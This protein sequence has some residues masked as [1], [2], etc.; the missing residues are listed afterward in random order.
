MSAKLLIE[1]LLKINF[2]QQFRASNMKNLGKKNQHDLTNN[3]DVND[4]ILSGSLYDEYR[5][6]DIN[7]RVRRILEDE[8]CRSMIAFLASR[9]LGCSEG[10][11]VLTAG[12]NNYYDAEGLDS[13][14]TIIFLRMLNL[15]RDVG[16]FLKSL[17]H[18]LPQKSNFVGCFAD[19]NEIKSRVRVSSSDGSH[20]KMHNGYFETNGFMSGIPLIKYIYN[21][22]DFKVSN[23][24]TRERVT[25]LIENHGFNV[26]EM[27]T[28]DGLVY[29]HAVR[30]ALET[31]RVSVHEL[32]S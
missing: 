30:S 21:F 17:Y 14:H 8:G 26:A 2:T 1:I 15:T 3:Q 22:R 27:K 24:L 7:D 10:T 16:N 5:E 31:C 12:N 19:G 29:F 32:N 23:Y 20:L 9:R 4:F 11:V 25:E 6:S 28:I 13:I 18:L